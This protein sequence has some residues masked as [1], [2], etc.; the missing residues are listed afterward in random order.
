MPVILK[1]KIDNPSGVKRL[2]FL[3]VAFN[4]C[5]PMLKSS[6]HLN[7]PIALHDWFKSEIINYF[8]NVT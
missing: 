6:V 3:L 4:D 7:K 8:N 2:P 1:S 5:L